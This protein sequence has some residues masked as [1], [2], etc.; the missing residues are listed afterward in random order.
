M[1]QSRIS[2]AEIGW[3]LRMQHRKALDVQL[4]NYR[5]VPRDVQLGIVAPIEERIDDHALW[6]E[7]RAVAI[8][9]AQVRVGMT[10]HVSEQRIVPAQKPVDRL[11]IR[12]YQQLRRIEALPFVRIVRSMD[13]IAVPQTRLGALQIDMPDAVGLLGDR[14]SAGLQIFVAIIVKTELYASRVFAE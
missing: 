4:V 6:D 3:Y 14:D 8:V 9:A 11:G 10:D 1:R 5:L 7:G 2:A 13:P 12:V